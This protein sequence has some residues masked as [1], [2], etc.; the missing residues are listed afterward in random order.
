ME[1]VENWYQKSFTHEHVV[2]RSVLLE[3]YGLPLFCALIVTTCNEL[4]LGRI[5]IQFSW[6][7]IPALHCV[8]MNHFEFFVIEDSC[9]S[10]F[11]VNIIAIF[12][13]HSLLGVYA[14][15]ILEVWAVV[16][17]HFTEDLSLNLLNELLEGVSV[18]K[19]SFSWRVSVEVEEE[20]NPVK[21]LS[22]SL[23]S[24]DWLA[25]YT[26]KYCLWRLQ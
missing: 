20:V 19:E 6:R 13:I 14:V 24:P 10:F 21:R 16:L 1:Y 18:N 11:C 12:C 23:N 17:Q 26:S 2:F 25:D 7:K 4:S 5:T 3:I 8:R 15:Q 9:T 22:P